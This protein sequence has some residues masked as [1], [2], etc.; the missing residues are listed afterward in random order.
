VI[1]QLIFDPVVWDTLGGNVNF[2]VNCI[3]IGDDGAIY[4]A[5][6]SNSTGAGFPQIRIY[7]WAAEDAPMTKIFAGDPTGNNGNGDAINKRWGDT[8]A[9]RGAGLN[10]QILMASRGTQVAIFTP[11][12]SEM[13]NFVSTVLNTDAP[14]GALGTGICFGPGDTFYGTAGASTRGPLYLM[15]F[16][17]GAGTATNLHIYAQTEFAGSVSTIGVNTQSNLLVG[18]EMVPGADVVRLYDISNTATAPALL[19]REYFVTTNDNNIFGGAVAFADNRVFV[20]D[21]ENGIMAYAYS[22]VVAELP[23]AIIL[24]PVGT[25]LAAGANYTL[26]VGAD[27]SAP[28][29]Y[30]WRKSDVDLV[31]ETNSNLVLTNIQ[32]TGSYTVIVSNSFG[33][34]TSSAVSV[35]V[36]AEVGNLIW[37]DSMDYTVGTTLSGQGNWV[38]NNGTAGT[39]EAGNLFVTGLEESTGNRFTWANVA[40]NVR[41][42][43]GEIS[44][45]VVYYSFILQCPDLGTMNNN[46]LLAGFTT[47]TA[48]VYGTRVQIRPGIVA[49]TYNLGV[50]KNAGTAA[51]A[52]NDFTV[53][54]V[55]FVVGKYTFRT[56]SGTDD[57]CEMWI[58]PDPSSFGSAVPPTPTLSVTSGNDFTLLNRFNFRAGSSTTAPAKHIADEVR[59]ATSWALVTPQAVEAS[60]ILSVALNASD[61]VISWPTNAIDFNLESAAN[62][63]APIG[64]LAVTNPVVVNGTNNTVTISAGNGNQF[65]QL[66]K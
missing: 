21:S 19:D 44:D 52:T 10:T 5:N 3:G 32:Q 6:L 66:R 63:N 16:N 20:L 25:T 43:I 42:D 38:L 26:V 7:R 37:K 31:G 50:Q 65:F 39:I 49:G 17:L 64:W 58:N 54:D 11:S 34:V 55:I 4:V 9:V 18:V 29:F 35:T 13:T 12:D 15:G 57:R 24:P 46:G 23:P 41:R 48:T 1:G 14:I 61:V 28:L 40:M 33:S 36:S 59:V 30:Q 51:Y 47:N 60:P 22:N 45:G 27:G 53:N 56:G 2:T 8:L 62:L